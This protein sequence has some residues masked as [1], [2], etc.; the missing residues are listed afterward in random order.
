M[1]LHMYSEIALRL[2]TVVTAGLMLLMVRVSY[3]YTRCTG[4]AF[5]VAKFFAQRLVNVICSNFQC[6][7]L[8][9]VKKRLITFC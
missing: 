7:F 9:A 3:W 8:Q 4:L 1:Y 6:Q 5:P 2:R